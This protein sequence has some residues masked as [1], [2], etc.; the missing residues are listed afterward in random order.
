MIRGTVKALG[1]FARAIGLTLAVCCGMLLASYIIAGV[2][3]R[4]DWDRVDKS[5]E[6][7]YDEFFDN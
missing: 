7:A 5:I 4:G 1:F 3:F 2:M 6:R